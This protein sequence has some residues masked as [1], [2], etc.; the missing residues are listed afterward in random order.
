MML[1][2]CVRMKNMTVG[3]PSRLILLF[4]I[5]LIIGNILQQMYSFIDTLIVGRTLGVNALAAVGST[6]SLMFLLIGIVMGLTNGFAIIAGHH[7]GAGDTDNVRRSVAA[8]LILSIICSVLLTAGSMLLSRPLLEWMQTPPEILPDASVF[9]TI[10]CAGT[11]AFLFLNLLSNL[12]RAFGNSRTPLYFLL[13]STIL[14]VVLELLFL[15]GFGWG[16]AGAAAATI[17]AIALTTIIYLVYFLRSDRL[18]RFHRQDW[19]PAPSVWFTHLRTGCSMAFQ[20]STVAV[21][22]I[23]LQTSLNQFGATAIAAYSA[24]QKID[25]I[26]NMPM[27]SFGMAMAA[28]TAQNFGAQKLSRIKDGVRAC[29]RMSVSFALIIGLINMT[30]GPFLV[31]LFVGS[32]EQEVIELAQIYLNRTGLAYFVLALLFIYRYT[33]QGLGKNAVPTLSGFIELAVRI[34]A[35]VVIAS[36]FGYS[37]LCLSAPLSWTLAC[38]PL[39]I[40]YYVTIRTLFPRTER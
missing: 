11:G 14:N 24:A 23:I 19:L 3:S 37:G 31:S 27:M 39:A 16:I 33:L 5:P 18:F 10:I 20:S 13:L 12:S 9:L 30:C 38:I 32:E 35:A 15:L 17:L 34:F 21:G 4:T 26:A 8:S 28:Y 2:R 6:G 40:A 29:I 36:Y 1:E 25:A 22:A 7:Y